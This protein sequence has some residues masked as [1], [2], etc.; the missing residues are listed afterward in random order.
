MYI[1]GISC[2]P[3]LVKLSQRPFLQTVSPVRTTQQLAPQL[4]S[5]RRPEEKVHDNFAATPVFEE[6]W[7]SFDCGSPPTSTS[8]FSDMVTPG[9]SVGIGEHTVSSEQGVQQDSVLSK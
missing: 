5:L 2:Y 1:S 6:S 3:K 7:P 8:I 4:H 9:Q